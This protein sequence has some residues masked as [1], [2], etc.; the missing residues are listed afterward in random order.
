MNRKKSIFILLLLCVLM[1]PATYASA[2][3]VIGNN[4]NG[5]PDKGL[6]R[7]I[8]N[9]LG[10]KPKETFTRQEAEQIRSL[11]VYSNIKNIKGIKYLKNLKKLSI[12][13]KRLKSLNGI[14]GLKKLEVINMSDNNIKSLKPLKNLKNL[15]KLD[16]SQNLSLIHI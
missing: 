16:A 12:E 14:Q 9:K 6:Y 7:D 13:G 3:D 1:I 11:S 4:K 15:K 8:L 10:K 2:S 5:I